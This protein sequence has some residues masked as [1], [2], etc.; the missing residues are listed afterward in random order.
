MKGDGSVRWKGWRPDHRHPEWDAL[1]AQAFSVTETDTADFIDAIESYFHEVPDL[2]YSA[3]DGLGLKRLEMLLDQKS[4]LLIAAVHNPVLHQA[5]EEKALDNRQRGF[6]GER[7]WPKLPLSRRYLRTVTHILM[8]VRLR[9]LW[10]PLLP[11][12]QEGIR[13]LL[14][15]QPD[16]LFSGPRTETHALASL[17]P[18]LSPQHL[19]AHIT[20]HDTSVVNRRSEGTAGWAQGILD[21]HGPDAFQELSAHEAAQLLQAR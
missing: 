19:L 20:E 9:E 4:M 21:M 1:M 17:L 16:L 13:F 12:E 5:L 8:L 3:T 15:G 7:P 11:H 18:D 6:F 14:R 2:R 10:H